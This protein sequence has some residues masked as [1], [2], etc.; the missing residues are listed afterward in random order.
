MAEFPL[1]VP[2]TPLTREALEAERRMNFEKASAE[3]AKAKAWVQ[4][5]KEE[6][7]NMIEKE[8]ELMQVKME[9][10]DEPGE[11]DAQDLMVVEAKRRVAVRLA[12][13]DARLERAG[14][15]VIT[16]ICNEPPFQLVKEEQVE[17]AP[18]EIGETLGLL[19]KLDGQMSRVWQRPLVSA[20]LT[21][22]CLE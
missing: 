2:R 5:R 12:K 19:M 17:E 6:T 15:K 4:A 21:H 9:V 1:Y 3:I 7:E 22:L 8:L 13:L 18:E 14:Q 16:L 11:E 10:K 20:D